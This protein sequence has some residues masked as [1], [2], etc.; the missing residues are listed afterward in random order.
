MASKPLIR[1]SFLPYHVTLRVNNREVFPL[2][3]EVVWKMLKEQ[4]YLAFA[5]HG[6]EI[7]ALVLMYN[8]LHLLLTTPADDLG[9]VMRFFVSELTR[10]LNPVCG[11]SNRIFGSRYHPTLIDSELY[12]RTVLKYIYRN[13]VRSGTVARVEDYPFS[14]LQG[15]MGNERLDFPMFYPRAGVGVS[16]PSLDAADLLDW[17]NQPF[18]REVE[19]GVRL[20][21]RRKVFA[22]PVERASRKKLFVE[23]QAL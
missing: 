7:Q 2:P 6:V 17:L 21:L 9:V 23:G 22:L 4:C 19:E 5:C 8:H 3:M 14:T 16:L 1:S 15:L 11:R 10:R 12:F 20:G 13:P 18:Q